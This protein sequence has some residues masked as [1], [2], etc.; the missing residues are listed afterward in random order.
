MALTIY[1]TEDW[2]SFC[3]VLDANAIM[4]AQID[5]TAWTALTE[6]QKEAYLKQATLLIRLRIQPPDTLEDDLKL[7]TAM[8]ANYS[9]GKE[10]TANDGNDNVKRIKIDGAL[11]KEYFTKASSNTEF[12]YL[13]SQLLSQ[14]GLVSGSTFKI[15]RTL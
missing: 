7:A 4:S 10:V 15:V 2:N 1:P 12:P 13:V 9:I 11:E 3:S 6:A 8:L 14:Y 5:S